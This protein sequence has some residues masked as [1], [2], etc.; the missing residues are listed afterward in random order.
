MSR[1]QSRTFLAEHILHNNI[2]EETVSTYVLPMSPNDPAV[3]RNS[4]HM[5]P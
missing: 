5:C 4:K 1:N 3:K 2:K